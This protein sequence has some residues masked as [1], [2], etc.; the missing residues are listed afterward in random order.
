[1]SD[2]AQPLAAAVGDHADAVDVP[3]KI[4]IDTAAAAM[5]VLGN[6]LRLEIW[7]VLVP[8]GPAGL[9]AGAVATRF[10][11][12]ASTISFHLQQMT[13]IGALQ[14]RQNGRHS[15]YF[16]QTEAF[17]DLCDFLTALIRPR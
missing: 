6:K 5:T 3:S 2:N 4:G 12:P 17:A 8:Y 10:A 1:M 11:M 13:K 15:I 16:V 14:T 7:C 9:T